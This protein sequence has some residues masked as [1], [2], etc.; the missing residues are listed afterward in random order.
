MA[1]GNLA[2]SEKRSQNSTRGTPRNAEGIFAGAVVS[3]HVGKPSPSRKII[4][5]RRD[6]ITGVFPSSKPKMGH[7]MVAYEGMLARDFIALIDCDPFVESYQEEPASFPWTDGIDWR[8]YTP[9]FSVTLIDGRKICVEVKPHRRVLKFPPSFFMGISEASLGAGYS[10]FEVWTDRMMGAVA[11]ANA[12]LLAS[13]RT[14]ITNDSEL[15]TIRR[16]T[17]RVDSLVTIRELRRISGLGRRAYRAVI[18]LIARGELLPV[19]P[20]VPLDDQAL[21]RRA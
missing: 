2:L 12:G 15:F 16:A 5:G 11:V 6:C 10:A 4:T 19:H 3:R 9:D 20:H 13:E 8:T 1:V 14:F 17:D 18:G 21:L 7:R